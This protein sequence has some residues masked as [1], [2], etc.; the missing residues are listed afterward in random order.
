V[1]KAVLGYLKGAADVVKP[2][3]CEL[4]LATEEV[5]RMIG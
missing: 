1:S 4:E 5:G 2:Q 3:A